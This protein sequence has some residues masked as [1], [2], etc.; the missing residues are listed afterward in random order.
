MTAAPEP[1]S[2]DPGEPR[3][4]EAQRRAGILAELERSL[5][6]GLP[7]AEDPG[8]QYPPAPHRDAPP[9]PSLSPGALALL[10]TVLAVVVIAVVVTL[11]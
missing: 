5:A 6:E 9:E 4:T 10:G 1:P 2:D 11:P 8:W 7:A 3:E